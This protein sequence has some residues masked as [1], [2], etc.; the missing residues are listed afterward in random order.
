VTRKFSGPIAGGGTLSLRLTDGARR[1]KVDRIKIEGI[2]AECRGGTAT[3]DYRIFG[4]T[5][6]DAEG[7]FAVKSQDSWKGNAL[8]KG[9]FSPD[10]RLAEGTARVW[11]RFRFPK[12][13]PARCDSEKQKYAVARTG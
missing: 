1:D 7:A 12:K 11:G 3:L 5:P 10:L 6:V 8:V 9:Q 2:P 13:G 4:S